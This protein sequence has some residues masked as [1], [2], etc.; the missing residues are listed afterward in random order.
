MGRL[1]GM[2]KTGQNVFEC[3]H[4]NVLGHFRFVHASPAS[5]PMSGSFARR[6]NLSYDTD[7][8][9]RISA[10]SAAFLEEVSTISCLGYGFRL[11]SPTLGLLNSIRDRK[12]SR[13]TS[14]RFLAVYHATVF[15]HHNLFFVLILFA[16][17][18]FLECKRKPSSWTLIA[19]F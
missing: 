4:V 10:A 18:S 12:T 1:Q 14:Q 15:I 8:G 11:H 17:V 16:T 19:C 13:N 7:E 9:R 5:D 6:A 3:R 2:S